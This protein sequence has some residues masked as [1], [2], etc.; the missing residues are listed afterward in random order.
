MHADGVGDVGEQPP[1]CDVR[2]LLQPRKPA[3]REAFAA[4]VDAGQGI[5]HP[6]VGA[7]GQPVAGRDEEAEVEEH[8]RR[9]VD[10]LPA[11]GGLRHPPPAG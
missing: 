3:R 1:A 8:I 11:R 2:V 10:L 9:D 6:I 4:D 7:D 5:D